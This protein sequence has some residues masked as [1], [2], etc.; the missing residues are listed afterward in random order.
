MSFITSSSSCIF[1]N[2]IIE[3]MINDF[4][5]KLFIILAIY[6]VILISYF[7]INFYI[8]FQKYKK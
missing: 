2:L 3:Y 4:K 6:A 5:L 8:I 7:I 1:F